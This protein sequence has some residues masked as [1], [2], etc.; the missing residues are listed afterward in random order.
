MFGDGF[1]ISYE[2]TVFVV[3]GGREVKQKVH[4]E[5][6]VFDDVKDIEKSLG[7]CVESESERHVEEVVENQKQ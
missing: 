5:E 7:I 3:V 4:K 1:G 2:V 6:Q